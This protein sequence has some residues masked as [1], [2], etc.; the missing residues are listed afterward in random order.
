MNTLPYELVLYIGNYLYVRDRAR[1]YISCRAFYAIGYTDAQIL[2]MCKYNVVCNDID[3]IHYNIILNTHVYI[4]RRICTRYASK[5][6]GNV[7]ASYNL[8][9]LHISNNFGEHNQIMVVNNRVI[10]HKFTY[11]MQSMLETTYNKLQQN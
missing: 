8:S 4:S 2:H 7:Y 5:R 6:I 1:L 11:Y 9:T 3:K 10:I